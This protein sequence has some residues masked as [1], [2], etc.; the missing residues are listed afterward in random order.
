MKKLSIK[1]ENISKIAKFQEEAKME[2]LLEKLMGKEARNI[3]VIMKNSMDD[4]T[5]KVALQVWV[6]LNDLLTLKGGAVEAFNRLFQ[7]ID[8]GKNYSPEMHRNNIF[9]AADALG[10]KLPSGVF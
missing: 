1:E 6:K 8:A 4:Q 3:S 7:S 9:K 2:T 10:L 5:R